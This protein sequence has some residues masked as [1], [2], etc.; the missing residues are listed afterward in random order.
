MYTNDNALETNNRFNAADVLIAISILFES[1]LCV[2][3][4]FGIS[5]EVNKM[6]FANVYVLFFAVLFYFLLVGVN[7]HFLIFAFYCCFFLFLLGQKMFKYIETGGYDEFLTFVFLKLD[8]DEYF[9]FSFI[10]Y[11]ALTGI[12]AGYRL[13]FSR[14]YILKY[15]DSARD[16]YYCPGAEDRLA[17]RRRIIVPM[18]AVCFVCALYM[19]V[20]IV[21]TKADVS[22]TEGYLINVDVNPIIKAGNYLFVGFLFLYL[23]CR[24]KLRYAAVVLVMFLIVEGGLQMFT[25]RRALIAKTLLLVVWYVINYFGYE[26][27]KMPYRYLIYLALAALGGILLFW[28]IEQIRS[29][30]DKSFSLFG[31][32]KDFLVSTGGSD[33]VIANT[34]RNKDAF[35]KHGIVYLLNPIT[36]TL[37]GNALINEI[38]WR[39]FGIEIPSYVQGVDYIAHSD[40]F[41]HWISYIVNP[42][43]YVKGYGMGSSFIAELYLAFGV[44]GVIVGAVFIGRIIAGLTSFNINKTSVVKNAVMLFFAYNLFTLPRSGV[45]DTATELLYFLCAVIIYEITVKAFV[46]KGMKN[47]R[48]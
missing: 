28:L 21:L 10:V 43:L 42:D 47:E 9:K 34:I 3:Q 19:Q 16:S 37:F 48:L 15:R 17:A 14:Y 23:C 36:E 6:M 32:V 41:A 44:V 38:K 29:D 25:G 22:Y 24:P 30:A 4:L 39:L 27:K 26:K 46:A 13:S 40:S 8:P 2:M 20:K 11:G 33:S 12:F 1:V 31:A 7:K 5:E 45:F 18:L 35:P